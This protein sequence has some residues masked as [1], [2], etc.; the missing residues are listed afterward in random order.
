MR[1]IDA[2]ALMD[3]L[4]EKLPK[5]AVFY[6]IPPNAIENAPTVD[7][8]PVV[9]GRWL[10]WDEKFPG[11]ATE[12]DLGFFC[13]ACGNHADYS[14]P[15]C[16]NCGAEMD[17][18]DGNGREEI[19]RSCE[20]C[21]GKHAVPYEKNGQ[22]LTPYQET[23]RTKLFIGDLPWA[24]KTLFVRSYY[25]PTYGDSYCNGPRM[26]SF[27]INFCPH[28]GRDLRGDREDGRS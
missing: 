8:V 6:R 23:F 13:S 21:D 12:K 22:M 18:E 2:D 20:F 9:R 17:E 3:E 25:C 14:S 28:C 15:Y 1:L 7:A 19:A 5:G 26:D 4:L 27:Q 24:G 11:R 10:T 16:P